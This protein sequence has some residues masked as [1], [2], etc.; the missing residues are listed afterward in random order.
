MERNRI[1]FEAYEGVGVGFLWEKSKILGGSLSFGLWHF[2]R[3]KFFFSILKI[4]VF[5]FQ[6]M[7]VAH[8]LIKSSLLDSENIYCIE[9]EPKR[10][11][12]LIKVDFDSYN[13]SFV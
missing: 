3:L 4:I 10:L 12:E 8:G 9:H 2:Q 11:I 5:F 6:E 7:Y 1:F 13:I